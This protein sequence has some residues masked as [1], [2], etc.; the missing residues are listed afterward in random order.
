MVG[1]MLVG[2]VSVA[3]AKDDY[4]QRA[5]AVVER[6][7]A[8]YAIALHRHRGEEALRQ[9]TV[10]LQ[11]RNEELDAFAHTVAHDL[12]GPLALVI[13]FAEVLEDTHATLPAGDLVGY[14]HIIARDA[15]KVGNI[16]D[17]LLLLA[18][19]RKAE[20]GGEPLDMA[21]IVAEA[22]RRLGDMID[23]YQAEIILP[24]AWPLAL[25][26]A[27]WIEEVWVNYLSHAV[28]YG[29]RPPRIELGA[30]VEEDGTVRFWVRDNGHGLAP[31][32]QERL[33]VPFTQLGQSRVEGYGLGLSIVR[34]IVERL[35]GR[36]GV[37]SEG[38]P[39]RGS[40][41]TFTLPGVSG[42]V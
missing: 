2:Q 7:A 35:G 31:E 12:K 5:L 37:E 21:G 27:P 13:G 1:D 14:L 29:G 38:V 30:E 24:P 40:V 23:E 9:R 22:R 34:R 4:T 33:F 32:E 6:L 16:I 26:H 25:G 41:F 19:V 20:V 36:V 3:N 10:E 8:L 42:E 28:R 17:E 18:S 15:R 11:A 39:G